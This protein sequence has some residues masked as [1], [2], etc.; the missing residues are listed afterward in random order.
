LARRAYAASV[1][2]YP[3]TPYYAGTPR[4]GSLVLGYAGLSPAEIRAGVRVL[5]D[6]LR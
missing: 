1:G 2:V 3:A 6:V 5:R 4:E